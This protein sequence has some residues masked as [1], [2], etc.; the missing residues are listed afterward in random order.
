M[1]DMIWY[2][3]LA[4]QGHILCHDCSDFGIHVLLQNRQQKYQTYYLNP[5]KHNKVNYPW[6]ITCVFILAIFQL[7]TS[8]MLGNS[9]RYNAIE[10]WQLSLNNITKMRECSRTYPYSIFVHKETPASNHTQA[11]QNDP[12]SSP[13]GFSLT[14]SFTCRLSRDMKTGISIKQ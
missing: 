8:I 12:K 4:V 11:N 6:N 5:M 7:Y 13:R 2:F 1:I 9:A 3:R 14:G 10:T